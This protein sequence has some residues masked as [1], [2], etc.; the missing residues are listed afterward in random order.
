MVILL[1]LAC[2]SEPEAKT[3]PE[4]DPV[5]LLTRLSLDLRGVRPSDDEI[6]RVEADEAA[7]DELAGELLSDERFGVRV[8]DL[9]SEIYLTRTES[10]P[11]SAETLGLSDEAA[12]DVAL[13]EEPLRIVSRVATE[14]LPYTEVVLADW[15]M[16]NEVL[17]A[18]L[19]LDYPD[20]ETGWMEARY[21]DGR[22]PAGVL[23]TTGLWW[24]YTSTDSNA[25][26]RRANALSR[27]LLCNDYAGRAID[28][29][30][31][32]D[33][34]DEE[35]I[36]DAIQTNPACVNCHN[37]LDPIASYLF[38][39][40][41]YNDNSPLEL[42]RYHPEREPLW[43]EYTGVTPSWYGEAGSSLSDLA[44]QIA[45]DSRFPDCAVEQVTSLLLR[46]ALTVDDETDL[47]AHRAA[48]LAGGLTLRALFR[49]VL[50]DDSY[51]AAPGGLDGE[52]ADGA[53]PTKMLS[54]E[55][56]A[57]SVEALTGF[58]WTY[59]GYEMLGTDS[60]GLR[61]LAGGVD[62]RTITAA[63]AAPNATL[64]LVQERLA[65]AAA[66]YAVSAEQALDAGAR[67]LF[68]EIDFTE[69]P[70]NSQSAITAQIQ[71]LQLRVLGRRVAADS[72]EVEANQE[73]WDELYAATGSTTE[74]WTGLLS[75][76]LRD[77]DFL[78]Y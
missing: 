53:A 78:L 2:R 49:S 1:L 21:T 72:P 28:F 13:G 12:Y 76:L 6:A 25:N 66:S 51:R 34:L 26:R 27:I 45:S 36:Q 40:W 29:D 16:A 41:W 23:A 59:G 56:L 46:R 14:D 61:T 69:T 32:L 57:S 38:G 18:F 24:R 11:V 10:W 74:T 20:G 33:L 42:T 71:A 15:T 55:Q 7:V 52:D 37:S 54:A 5:R 4:M 19:P 64:I 22:P 75:A 43:S 65:E 70:E 73:L 3:S 62:G 44:W 63:A 47:E 31:D 9:F 67:R 68:T 48:F 35:A 50:Q 30:R 60:V 8:R 77:P 17:A 58:R 39:F